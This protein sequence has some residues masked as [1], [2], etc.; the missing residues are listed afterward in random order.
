VSYVCLLLREIRNAKKEK[1][2]TIRRAGTDNFF[3]FLNEL[4]EFSRQ[5]L[6]TGTD[7][8]VIEA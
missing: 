7:Q 2:G 4:T 3:F 5:F 1:K 6:Y 8:K